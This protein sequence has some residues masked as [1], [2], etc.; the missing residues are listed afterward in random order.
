M[1]FGTELAQLAI[2]KL[3]VAGTKFLRLPHRSFKPE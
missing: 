2:E 3:S 1:V